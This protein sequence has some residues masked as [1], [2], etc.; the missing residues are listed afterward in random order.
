MRL[1]ST[2][3]RP[4]YRPE[5]TL[6][7]GESSRINC[8]RSFRPWPTTSRII[9]T[10]DPPIPPMPNDVQVELSADIR[11]L[12]SGV[13]DEMSALTTE[14]DHQLRYLEMR[15]GVRESNDL[16]VLTILASVFLPLS[17]ASSILSMGTRLVDLGTLLYDFCG[18]AVILGSLSIAIIKLVRIGIGVREWFADVRVFRKKQSKLSKMTRSSASIAFSTLQTL[19]GLSTWAV[20][21]SSFVVGMNGG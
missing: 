17:L 14:L 12:S 21:F 9:H 18:V 2:L 8:P 19:A 13:K 6:P 20:V 3:P 15:R 4:A 5:W 16:W 1:L 10:S 7:L 11:G